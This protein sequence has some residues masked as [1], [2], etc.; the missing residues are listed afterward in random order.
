MIPSRPDSAWQY[1]DL[2]SVGAIFIILVILILNHYRKTGSLE[3][4]VSQ[5]VAYSKRSSLTFSI[6]VTPFFPLY[7]GFL[8]FWVAPLTN[9]PAY[10]YYLLIL[11]AIC[12][13][14]F[15]WVPATS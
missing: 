11:S 8:Y 13:L 4:T 9:M 10:F 2:I 12:E 1:F 6:L 14:I 7:Y 3:P 5:T 15:V